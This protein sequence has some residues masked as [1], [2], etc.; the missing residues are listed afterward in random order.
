MKDRIFFVAPASN[1]HTVRWVNALSEYFEVHLIYCKNH[2]KGINEIKE[3]V[4]LHQLTFKS[5]FGYYLNAYKLRKLYKEIKPKLIN[6]H[7][8][9]GYGTLVRCAKIKPVLLSVWGSDVYDFPN[10]SYINKMILKKNVLSATKITSTSHV[11]EKELKRQVSEI[12]TE[13]YITP[14]GVDINKFKKVDI[15]R[16]NDDINIVNIKA[17]ERRYGIEELILSVKKLKENLIE[18][19]KEQIADKVKLYIY[20]DGSEKQNLEKLIESENLNNLVYLKGK[21][22]NAEVPKILNVMD[23]FCAT[24]INE[25][26]GVAVVE[27]MACELPVV[28]TKVDGFL[29]VMQDKNTGYLVEVGNIDKIAEILEKL[30]ENKQLRKQLGENGRK[31]V[32]ENYNWNDNVK[33]M[34]DIYL[35]MI[36]KD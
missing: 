11:M 15:E 10:R 7:F 2:E 35:K 12:E 23:I 26:F 32:I 22:A 16:E 8:A 14:F 13:I 33:Y 34:R 6:V 21:V 17:L 5:P 24:S 25:S 36:S 19:G 29:E 27:A 31:R 28:D 20:G 4:I 18:K 30:I 1:I 9:S 3:D